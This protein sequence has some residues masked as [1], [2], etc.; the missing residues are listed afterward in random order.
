MCY[1]C[2]GYSVTLD[3]KIIELNIGWQLMWCRVTLMSK[4]TWLTWHDKVNV[5]NFVKMVELVLVLLPSMM[6]HEFSSLKLVVFPTY[7]AKQVA[8]VTFGNTLPI[9]NRIIDIKPNMLLLGC[10]V[11]VIG[12]SS[13]CCLGMEILT[14]SLKNSSINICQRCTST[15]G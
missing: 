9:S 12:W 7:F 14:C 13:T 11:E 10:N 6:T 5:D 1:V 15:C 3:T 8:L 2:K 4:Q